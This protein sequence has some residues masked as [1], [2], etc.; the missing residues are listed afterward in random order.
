MKPGITHKTDSRRSRSGVVV[1]E[2]STRGGKRVGA[3]APESNCNAQKKLLM[4]DGHDLS[5]SV[6]ICKFLREFVVPAAVTGGLGV[7]NVT[8][9]TSACKVL[10]DYESLE[11]IEERVSKLENEKVKT[12]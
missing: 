11:K 1:H 9:I 5:S 4:P 7:R 2:Q 12:N 8:A 6:G 10:L 3:G